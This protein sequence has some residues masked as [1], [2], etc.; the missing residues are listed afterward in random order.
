MTTTA[1]LSFLLVFSVHAAD[2][3]NAGQ[4][5]SMA[6]VEAMQQ[7]FSRSEKAHSQSMATIMQSMSSQKAW[8]V[9]E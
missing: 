7:V 8:D 5:T 4:L 9:L 1:L 3:A 2:D 6:S